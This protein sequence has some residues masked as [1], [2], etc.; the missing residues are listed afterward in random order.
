MNNGP[1]FL[2]A[3]VLA[4]T[5]FITHCVARGFLEEGVRRKAAR[6]SEAAKQRSTYVADPIAVQASHA[7]NVL[8]VTGVVLTVLSVVCMVTA[9]LRREPGW[10]LTLLLVLVFDILMPMLL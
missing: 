4:I 5:A 2:G 6:M 3:M 7:W 9:A 10:Y 1:F 8:T